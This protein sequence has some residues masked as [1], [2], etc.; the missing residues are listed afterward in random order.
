[1]GRCQIASMCIQEG[2]LYVGTSWGCLIVADAETM[3]P[4]SV[5]RPYTEEIQVRFKTI[6]ELA[7]QFIDILPLGPNSTPRAL[8][9]HRRHLSPPIPN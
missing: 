2:K 7:N 8:S 1:M 5:F 3:R 4:V 9:S 6:N